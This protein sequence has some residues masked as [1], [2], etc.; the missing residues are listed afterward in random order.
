[1]SQ[2]MSKSLVG[3]LKGRPP[4][5]AVS[6]RWVM[7]YFEFSMLGCWVFLLFVDVGVIGTNCEVGVSCFFWMVGCFGLNHWMFLSTLLLFLIFYYFVIL[8]FPYL[9][10]LIEYWT[11]WSTRSFVLPPFL[12]FGFSSIYWYGFVWLY[13]LQ[14]RKRLQPRIQIHL[15]PICFFCHLIYHP[16]SSSQDVIE[17]YLDRFS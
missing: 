10:V 7:I 8:F 11:K 1:M 13:W 2:Q 14:C 17:L 16:L 15:V 6:M 9:L 12:F 4:L 3:R 5:S